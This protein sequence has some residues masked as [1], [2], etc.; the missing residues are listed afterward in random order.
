MHISSC[1]AHR[2]HSRTR[3]FGH[4][5]I[6]HRP[7][8]RRRVLRVAV[9]LRWIVRVL[10]NAASI[11]PRRFF[12]GTFFCSPQH[13]P[14]CGI[15]GHEHGRG[16]VDRR[17]TAPGDDGPG[18]ALPNRARRRVLDVHTYR[19]ESSRQHH[20]GSVF[21]QPGCSKGCRIRARPRGVWIV[22][23]QRCGRDVFRRAFHEP[24]RQGIRRVCCNR[25]SQEQARPGHS[26]GGVCLSELWN[27]RGSYVPD[28]ESGT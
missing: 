15:A 9:M 23:S 27:G 7:G 22:R 5:I 19:A 13:G 12:V 28:V 14:V 20:G 8:R 2:V 10:W 3:I 26:R 21:E 17:G 25:R 16:N 6:V 24:D 4:A 11:L 1:H 18:S